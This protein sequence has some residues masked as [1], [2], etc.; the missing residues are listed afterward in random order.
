[1]KLT[2]DFL[3]ELIRE[4]LSTSSPVDP[5]LDVPKEKYFGRDPSDSRCFAK[6]S[7]GK[8]KWDEKVVGYDEVGC[9]E[10]RLGYK[11]L[12]GG[13]FRLVFE[14]PENP[15]LIFKVAYD[16]DGEGQ[17]AIDRASE[18]NRKEAEAGYQASSPLVPKV[19]DAAE[20]YFWIKSEKVIVIRS[21]G[22]LSSMTSFWT[23]I[24]MMGLHSLKYY[25][26]DLWKMILHRKFISNLQ[27]KGHAL[28][29]EIFRSLQSMAGVHYQVQMSMAEFNE[30]VREGWGPEDPHPTA[31]GRE[32][33]DAARGIFRAKK[34]TERALDSL[35]NDPLI[36]DIRT[37]LARHKLPH[38]DIRPD[39]VGYVMR[40][41]KKQF[42][43]LDPGFELGEFGFSHEK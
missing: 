27:D 24:G 7:D 29:E 39:N 11:H 42:V 4:A 34:D 15:N 6:T 36:M 33:L 20:N 40:D 18:M 35:V 12:G 23:E 38:G 37:H 2:T 17:I 25:F 22:E 32:A 16:S 30:R 41:G 19:Y 14:I 5:A 10:H 26:S 43:I 28:T 9:L 13:A 31:Q 1:M 3:K 8:L 21:W